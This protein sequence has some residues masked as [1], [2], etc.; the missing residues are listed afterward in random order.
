MRSVERNKESVNDFKTDSRN[1]NLKSLSFKELQN[2]SSL[3]NFRLS[4]VQSN[5]YVLSSQI[6][7]LNEEKQVID[8]F[9]T[10]WKD[11]SER[12]SGNEINS[13]LNDKL[14]IIDRKSKR[15]SPK[16][17]KQLNTLLN[18]LDELSSLN[19]TIED[20][21]SEISNILSKTSRSYFSMD[22][23]P[24]WS[25][26]KEF[27][28]ESY[29]NSLSLYFSR[30]RSDQ[31]GMFFNH[32][33]SHFFMIIIFLMFLAML[34]K[35]QQNTQIDVK[36]EY[37][38]LE[39]IRHVY[40]KKVMTALFISLL[41]SLAVYR[42]APSIF[43]QTILL[44]EIILFIVLTKLVLSKE[45]LKQLLIFISFFFVLKLVEI[46]SHHSFIGHVL[47]TLI[48]VFFLIWM[49]RSK[50]KNFLLSGL[51]FSKT[52]KFITLFYV[53]L[54]YSVMLI[55]LFT[56]I[57][58]YINI[59]YYLTEAAISFSLFSIILFFWNVLTDNMFYIFLKIKKGKTFKLVYGERKIIY[60]YVENIISLFTLASV[61]FALL[62]TLAIRIY[63]ID[64]FWNIMESPIELGV[65][66]FTLSNI[67][68]FVIIIWFSTVI[69]RFIQTILRDEVLVRAKFDR[70]L[71]A[72]ISMLVRYS[73]VTLGFFVALRA[74]G[75]EFSQLT[76]I[77]GALSVG[78][79]FGLQSVF[80]NVVSGLILIFERPIHIGDTIEVNNIIGQV[81]EIGIRTSNIRSLDGAEVLIPNGLL[82][83][84]ELI[85]WTLSDKKRRIEII[86]GI[87]Y[88]SEVKKA[89]EIFYQIL[90]EHT[91]VIEDPAPQIIFSEFGDSSLNFR[92]LFWTDNYGDWLR[93]RSEILYTINEILEKEN[94]VIPFPQRDVHIQ[95]NS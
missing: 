93:I 48:N 41:F 55:S 22:I 47:L 65:F 29:T 28:T 5:I 24:I 85:N 34:N 64:G 21:I 16:F 73:V 42:D 19:F 10:F 45:R 94:I 12:N 53:K 79:G 92:I 68:L 39:N 86:I 58:G 49:M 7:K 38:F 74:M 11:Y 78:I 81:R 30:F 91:E 62:S 1:D 67:A 35:I 18:Q 4:Q 13:V 95:S 70:G 63:V 71:P 87:A 9:T 43:M 69:S 90:K 25:H 2:L 77:F 83:S 61:I 57:I 36:R 32:L 76:I 88:G 37:P 23:K 44:F 60:K 52:G 72:T 14:K 33:G 56:N 54:T 31:E 59:S 8:D 75:F 17:D 46:F 89:S 80:L 3:W 51:K 6:D 50:I 82:T 84:N 26:Y 40:G 15:G 27:K 66:S 20:R